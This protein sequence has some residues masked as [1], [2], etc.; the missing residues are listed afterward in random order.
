MKKIIY[1]GYIYVGLL[2]LYII[3]NCLNLPFSYSAGNIDSDIVETGQS[4]IERKTILKQKDNIL[5]V[6]FDELNEF[7]NDM[8][9]Y[10]NYSI[11]IIFFCPFILHIAIVFSCI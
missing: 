11:S 10:I 7:M 8:N 1:F 4:T 3:I 6:S 9:N 2:S 5:Y